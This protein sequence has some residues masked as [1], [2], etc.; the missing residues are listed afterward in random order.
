MN[1]LIASCA[2]NPASGVRDVG[3]SSGI[4]GGVAVGGGGRDENVR[5]TTPFDLLCGTTYLMLLDDEL[6]GTFPAST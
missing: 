5:I 2:P 1:N 4:P 6:V 3:G